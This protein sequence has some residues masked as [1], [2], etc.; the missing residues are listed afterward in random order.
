MSD[1]FREQQAYEPTVAGKFEHAPVYVCGGIGGSALA[2][3]AARFLGAKSYLIAHRDYGLPNPLPEGA[4]YIA[5]SYSGNTEETLSFAEAARANGFPLAV[6]ASGGTLLA[7]AKEQNLPYVELP[8]GIVPRD[9]GDAMTKALLAL[10]GERALLDDAGSIDES[11]AAE[12]VR[13]AK[14]FGGATPIFYASLRNEAL[15]YI[16]KVQCNETAKIPAFANV[17]PELNHNEMQGFGSAHA[18]KDFIAVFIKDGGD[19]ERIQRR[20]EITEKLLA[21]HRIKTCSVELPSGSRSKT[22]LHGW[23]LL[24]S[25]ARELANERGVE[26][27]A[28]PLVETFKASL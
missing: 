13:I 14:E 2:V 9:A 27:D 24:R 1:I 6:V 18:P 11:A 20:M 15:S 21:E 8:Q 28:T 5:L 17:F 16:G 3:L 22:L 19:H 23:W 25:L 4:S 12:G 10:I 7:F 26:P